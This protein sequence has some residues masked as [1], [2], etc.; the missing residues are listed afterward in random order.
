MSGEMVPVGAL[1]KAEAERDA[2]KDLAERA[3]VMTA[4]GGFGPACVGKRLRLTVGLATY[5]YQIVNRAGVLGA[6]IVVPGQDPA[7]KKG[8]GLAALIPTGGAR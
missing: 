4:I 2:Y 3:L 1:R 7:P 5:E 8:R 6:E